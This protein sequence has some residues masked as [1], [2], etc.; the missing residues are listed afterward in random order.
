MKKNILIGVLL[1][2]IGGLVTWFIFFKK[3]PIPEPQIS[4]IYLSDTI[5]VDRVFNVPIHPGTVTP[6]ITIIK[7]RTDSMALDSLNLIIGQQNIT[8]TSLKDS[9]T[10]NNYYL[11]Q[12]PYNPKLISFIL[13][14]DTMKAGLL[15]ISG[16]VE[17]RAWPIDLNNWEYAWDFNSDLTRHPTSSPPTQDMPLANFYVGGGVDL[18]DLS[19]Y[20]SGRVERDFR[21]I[22]LYG[23]ARIGLLKKET[24]GIYIGL[25]YKL[26][27]KNSNN[28]E[29]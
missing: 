10:I 12:F 15:S 23:D 20:L 1:L 2:I 16:V 5:Y 27:G 24:H 4:Y 13:R 8:I 18:I 7:Y 17:E 6:P 9:I 22:R 29:W 19:P 3:K 11:K 25:D 14:R 28:R 21:R 26:N